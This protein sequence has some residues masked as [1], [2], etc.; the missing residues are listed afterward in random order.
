MTDEWDRKKR[1][2]KGKDWA[3]KWV[4]QTDGEE[5][6]EADGDDVQ[7]ATTTQLLTLIAQQTLLHSGLLVSQSVRYLYF[8]GSWPEWCISSMI[9]SR[10][11][12]FWLETLDITSSKP[13]LLSQGE[14][15]VRPLVTTGANSSVSQVWGK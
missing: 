15:Y 14:P 7:T 5:T 11:I 3:K 2:E 13:V 12:P 6:S 10:D 4:I 1:N 9:Y 8:E